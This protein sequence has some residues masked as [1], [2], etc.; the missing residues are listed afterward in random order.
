MLISALW[1]ALVRVFFG[2]T[3]FPEGG[4]ANVNWPNFVYKGTDS[5]GV[6]V[7]QVT[8][9]ALG[10]HPFAVRVLTPDHPSADLPTGA[11]K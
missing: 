10:A 8:W 3:A 1:I 4:T 9:G 5:N 7:Y 2:S 11:R 6:R